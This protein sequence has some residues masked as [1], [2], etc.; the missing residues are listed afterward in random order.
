MFLLLKKDCR[1]FLSRWNIWVLPIMLIISILSI[2]CVIAK[3]NKADS[4]EQASII[5]IGLVMNEDS[6]YSD[7]LMEYMRED[8]TYSDY[9]SIIRLTEAE[10]ATELSKGSID[11]YVALPDGFIESMEHIEHL[12]VK[13]MIS[14]QNEF[15]SSVLDLCLRSYESYVS[16]VEINCVALSVIM[17]MQGADIKTVKQANDKISLELISTALNR[18]S[19]FETVKTDDKMIPDLAEYY[20]RAAF[21][22]IVMLMGLVPGLGILKEK[23]TNTIARWSTTPNSNAGFFYEKLI[24]HLLCCIPLWSMMYLLLCG[25]LNHNITIQEIMIDAAFIIMLGGCSILLAVIC[26]HE[27]DYVS[28]VCTGSLLLAIIGGGI[29]PITYLPQ[30]MV[31]AAAFTPNYQ[32]MKAITGSNEKTAL[33]AIIIGILCVVG[34]LIVY[35]RQNKK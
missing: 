10:A 31:K 1:Q 35:N 9:V 14:G 15:K 33:T 2:C 13:V 27:Q 3:S 7:M 23:S 19:I 20:V 29:I 17:E 8:K 12:P 16:S 30:D 4:K 6:L 21:I 22:M 18:N 26:R 34:A 24:L 32:Y 5:K 11:M 25:L 28:V